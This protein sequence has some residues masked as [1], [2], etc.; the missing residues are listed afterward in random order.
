[1][2]EAF[3]RVMEG[4][5]HIPRHVVMHWARRLNTWGC[6]AIYLYAR[7]AFMH[8]SFWEIY[9]FITEET[10]IEDVYI[11]STGD[12]VDSSQVRDIYDA[13]IRFVVPI[14]F[15]NPF[16]DEVIGRGNYSEAANRV[17][18]MYPDVTIWQTIMGENMRQIQQY[19][20]MSAELDGVE[21]VGHMPPV[22]S[23]ALPDR[24]VIEWINKN[25][26]ELHGRERWLFVHR[27]ENMLRQFPGQYRSEIVQSST[28]TAGTIYVSSTGHLLVHRSEE[29]G[30][31][32]SFRME[33][34]DR[35]DLRAYAALHGE[36]WD[37]E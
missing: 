24:K 20:E 32:R 12:W 34:M 29:Y 7:D 28:E 2:F 27:E 1:M 15:A 17:I 4:D 8:R 23:Y 18:Q 5:R 14:D 31:M 30:R 26:L 11:F 19:A 6:N 35:S 13:D 22:P 33:S 37:N 3:V 10:D 25:D 36:L 9:E 16:E 21:W